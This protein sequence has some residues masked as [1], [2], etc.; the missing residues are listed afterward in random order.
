MIYNMKQLT[1]QEITLEFTNPLTNN[2]DLII[3]PPF[4]GRFDADVSYYNN[5]DKILNDIDLRIVNYRTSE[6]LGSYPYNRKLQIYNYWLSQLL[7]DNPAK[8]NEYIDKLIEVHSNNI[9]EADRKRKLEIA[10]VKKCTKKKQPKPANI[11]VKQKS[12]N[13]FTGETEYIYTNLRTNH[14]V[15]SSNPDLLETL[16]VKQVKEKKTNRINTCAKLIKSQD[17]SL[18]NIIIKF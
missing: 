13:I 4:A 7:P 17:V 12:V 14:I 16:N 10:N 1:A 5:L 9:I 3:L 8:Y 15:H 18:K 11:Y 2:T 6:F